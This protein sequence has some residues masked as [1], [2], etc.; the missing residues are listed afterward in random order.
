MANTN[1][2]TVKTRNANVIAGIDKH[3]T[4]NVTIGGVPYTSAN[5]KEVFQVQ[6]T[7]LDTSD[8]L[9]KQWRRARRPS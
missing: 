3:L 1:R 7:A 4:A 6:S 2:P 9:H 5:L 8:T